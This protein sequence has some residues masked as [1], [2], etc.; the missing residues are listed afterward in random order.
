MDYSTTLCWAKANQEVIQLSSTVV[1]AIATGII[2]LLTW[3][4][5][6][7]TKHLVEETQLLRRA[8]TTP[9]ISLYLEWSSS[10]TFIAHLI[11][12]N[13]G[14]RQAR[15]LSF[16]ADP[17]FHISPNRKLSGYMF[18]QGLPALQ[19]NESRYLSLDTSEWFKM[20]MGT[21]EK[22]V[23]PHTK[24]TVMYKDIEGKS[25]MEVFSLDLKAFDES[26]VSGMPPSHIDSIAKSLKD[27]SASLTSID[28]KVSGRDQS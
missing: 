14:F 22:A 12:R 16:E 3:K 6:S 25:Y 5:T 7:W 23:P 8:Q 11:L 19:A 20:K 1:V 18:M 28:T 26:K 15:D 17:D 13:D 10:K 21:P 9:H 27:I 24:I 4:Y 2:A